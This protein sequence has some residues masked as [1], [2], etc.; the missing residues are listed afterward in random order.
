MEPNKGEGT[1]VDRDSII[2]KINDTRFIHNL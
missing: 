2:E 1:M